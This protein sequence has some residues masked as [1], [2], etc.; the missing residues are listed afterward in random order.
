MKQTNAALAAKVFSLQGG[1]PDILQAMGYSVKDAEFYEH[2]GDN[3]SLLRTGNK[4]IKE[5]LEPIQVKF[6]TPEER[7]KHMAMKK[8]AEDI[9]AAAKLK[10]DYAAATKKADEHTQLENA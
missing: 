7:A 10:E 4:L 1:I 5:A 8:Q 6:M 2:L 3:L 9:K